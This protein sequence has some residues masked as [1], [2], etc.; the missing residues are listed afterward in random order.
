MKTTRKLQE[1]KCINFFYHQE[2]NY[3]HAW[4]QAHPS[5]VEEAQLE[6]EFLL[7]QQHITKK[8]PQT[9]VLNIKEYKMS[10]AQSFKN[11]LTQAFFTPIAQVGIQRLSLVYGENIY[12]TINFEEAT[13]KRELRSYSVAAFLMSKKLSDGARR[14]SS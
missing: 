11:W 1:G 4:V 12:N 2:K 10:I 13:Q 8:Q 6:N 7:L 14:P 9:L 5:N 3:I